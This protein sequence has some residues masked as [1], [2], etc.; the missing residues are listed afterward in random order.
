MPTFTR[1]EIDSLGFEAAR[2]FKSGSTLHSSVVKIARDNSMNPEQ[3]KRLVE[4]ANTTAFLS[5]FKEKTG[6]QRMVEFDVADPEKVIDE[7]ISTPGVAAGSAGSPSL[8]IT[9]TIDRDSTSLHDSI[10]DENAVQSNESTDKVASFSELPVIK[11]ARSQEELPTLTSY[12]KYKAKDSLLTKLADCNYRASDLADSLA[13]R[14]RGIYTRDKYAGLELDALSEY[15]N[16]AL[17]ALQMIRSRLNMEKI[18]SSLS[19]QQEYF[20]QD[21]HIVEDTEPLNKVASIIK[22]C[23]EY[24]KLSA[25]ISYLSKL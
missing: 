9:I 12:D 23:D 25:S 8:A 20:L 11:L 15:G 18:S 10:S 7:A 4:S 1:H 14:F 3:I 21:R 16:E 5:A 13:D 17:P 6:N 19:P 22:L 24:K 2:E